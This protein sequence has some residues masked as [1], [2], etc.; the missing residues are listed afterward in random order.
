MTDCTTYVLVRDDLS[1]GE[2]ALGRCSSHERD[3]ERVSLE[4]LNAQR[5]ITT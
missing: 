3:E 2:T 1:M 4:V 5:L